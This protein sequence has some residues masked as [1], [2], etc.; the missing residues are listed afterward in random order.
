MGK[1]PNTIIRELY[2]KAE[3]RQNVASSTNG[4][5]PLVEMSKQDKCLYMTYKE[6]VQNFLI[7][8]Y[9]EQKA[10]KHIQQGIDY[11]LAFVRYNNGFKY[12]GF[13]KEVL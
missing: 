12:V 13:S 2:R 5:N 1:N 8:G 9:S 3:H 6:V 7:E 10:I 4:T 11:D